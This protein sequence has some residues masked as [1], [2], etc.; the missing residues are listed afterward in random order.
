MQRVKK[1][2]IFF[3]IIINQNVRYNLFKYYFT[4]KTN[5]LFVVKIDYVFTLLKIIS[6]L[7]LK[8][9]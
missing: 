2:K 4:F 3:F 7:E 6:I 1:I 9:T 8:N 5:S